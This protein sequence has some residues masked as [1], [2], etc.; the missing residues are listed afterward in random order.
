MAFSLLWTLLQ[1]LLVAAIRALLPWL[2]DRITADIKAGR[3][4]VILDSEVR[5]VLQN[6]KEAVR[7]AYRGN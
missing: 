1:P 2:I 5:Y 4:V 7:A 3:P 6:R